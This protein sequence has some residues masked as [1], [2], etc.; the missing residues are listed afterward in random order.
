MLN[1]LL[2]YLNGNKPSHVPLDNPSIMPDF[3]EIP[4]YNV[5]KQIYQSFKVFMKERQKTK[6]DRVIQAS[7]KPADFIGPFNMHQHILTEDLTS[8]LEKSKTLGCSIT[9]L[10]L[11]TMM[12]SI[13]NTLGPKNGVIGLVLPINVRPYFKKRQP[14]FGNYLY[15]PIIKCHSRNFH[16]KKQVLNHIK[17]QF[18]Q[19]KKQLYKKQIIF[20]YIIDVLS[21]FVGKKNYARAFRMMKSR[22]EL[23]WTGSFS[24]L[25]DMDN[26]NIYGNKAQV[27]E[28]IATIPHNGLFFAISSLNGKINTNITY[29]EAEFNHE[30]IK[31]ILRVFECELNK[32]NSL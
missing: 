11:T 17:S 19:H 21:T 15:S 26:L 10:L 2:S 1:S 22:G 4:F 13:L 18:T 27:C 5:P 8:I 24:N 32:F 12:I 7:R 25:G 29:Q 31:N 3:L 9:E 23:H 6:G 28:A 30:E 20:S 14:I 16:D